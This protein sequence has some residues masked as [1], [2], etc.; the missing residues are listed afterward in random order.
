M[1]TH[2]NCW[3]IHGG[4]INLTLNEQTNA[5]QHRH[6]RIHTSMDHNHMVSK[7][8]LLPNAPIDDSVSMKS[9]L[10]NMQYIHEEILI[11]IALVK[12]NKLPTNRSGQTGS[13]LIVMF[14]A[15]IFWLKF[16]HDTCLSVCW[17]KLSHMLLDSGC[18]SFEFIPMLGSH[19]ILSLFS[20]SQTYYFSWICC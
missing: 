13:R 15:S 16:S 12:I 8:V 4:R 18:I 17:S 7:F 3:F 6:T 11:D 9:T 10:K 14:I 19:W 1:K 5:N 2:S 20:S